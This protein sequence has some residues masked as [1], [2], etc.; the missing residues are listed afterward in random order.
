M[1]NLIL[2][3]KQGTPE[4]LRGPAQAAVPGTEARM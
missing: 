2:E 4:E 3:M 1:I